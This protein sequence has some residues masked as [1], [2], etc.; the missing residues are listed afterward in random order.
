MVCAGT[1][2]SGLVEGVSDT[3]PHNFRERQSQ[4]N[5]GTNTSVACFGHRRR[6]CNSSIMWGQLR[7]VQAASAPPA[8]AAGGAGNNN[9]S[10]QQQQ[11]QT[12]ATKPAASPPAAPAAVSASNKHAADT[13]TSDVPVTASSSADLIANATARS[14]V[15]TGAITSEHVSSSSK[16]KSKSEESD[17][18]NDAACDN[19]KAEERADTDAADEWGFDDDPFFK[20]DD[21]QGDDINTTDAV[22][23]N[24]NADE[25]D[26]KEEVGPA[27]SQ[28]MQTRSQTADGTKEAADNNNEEEEDDLV[29][30]SSTML[31]KSNRRLGASAKTR[32]GI[33]A[34]KKHKIQSKSNEAA[35]MELAKQKF[36]AA[37]R[38]IEDD[39][40]NWDF[41]D[42]D[43]ADA[44]GDG[45]ADDAAADAEGS[46]SMLHEKLVQYLSSLS[47]T[48]TPLV[49]SLNSLL[50]AEL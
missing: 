21:G 6:P 32:S 14:I 41:D 39:D 16:S 46:N 40:D 37:V 43:D 13:D 47:S 11:N 17:P 45:E 24:N 18:R 12:T 8:S 9:S 31:I 2:E 4:S 35:T 3:H 1:N 42:D 34:N 29:P 23:S 10:P 50:E 19:D 33:T 28:Q 22:D 44:S 49:R 5:G 25:K 38:K 27:K 26:E 20:D 36:A 7:P 30:P 48:D 15:G